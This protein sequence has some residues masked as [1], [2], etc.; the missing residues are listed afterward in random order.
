V[1]SFEIVEIWGF[2]PLKSSTEFLI[3]SNDRL[4]SSADLLV[5]FDDPRLSNGEILR[6]ICGG[7]GWDIGRG[8]IGSAVKLAVV[9]E[10]LKISWVAVE[11]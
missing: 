5:S 9:W 6:V 3:S 10:I 4:K 1:F 11:S 7:S 8:L 2:D